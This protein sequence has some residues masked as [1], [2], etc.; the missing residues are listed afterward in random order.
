[1]PIVVEC[2]SSAV[3]RRTE[4]EKDRADKIMT[5][6]ILQI[7][8]DTDIFRFGANFKIDDIIMI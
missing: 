5:V 6:S 4:T 1:V 7:V 8:R 2:R 3:L